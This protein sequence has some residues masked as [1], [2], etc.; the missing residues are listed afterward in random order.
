MQLRKFEMRDHKS[1]LHQFANVDCYASLDCPFV[2]FGNHEIPESG[3]ISKS[4]LLF[5]LA[6]HHVN[7]TVL[8]SMRDGRVRGGNEREI[9]F[10]LGRQFD[11][12]LIMMCVLSFSS[13]FRH[14]AFIHR[15]MEM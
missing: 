2:L 5:D 9:S 7:R 6:I 13:P 8:G 10:V 14:K 11:N 15:C 4:P 1:E 3:F 12:A